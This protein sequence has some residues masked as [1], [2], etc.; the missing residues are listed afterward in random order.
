MLLVNSR[1]LLEDGKS[2]ELELQYYCEWSVWQSTCS[3]HI[4]G[5]SS[6][7]TEANDWVADLK[8]MYERHAEKKGYRTTISKTRKLEIK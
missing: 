1:A 8:R 2:F 6:G 4:N 7:G 3:P 5:R